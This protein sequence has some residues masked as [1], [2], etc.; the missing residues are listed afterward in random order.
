VDCLFCRIAKGEIEEAFVHE[1][2]DLVAFLD[3]NPI[4]PGHLQIVPRFHYTTFEEMPAEL[5]AASIHL[6][7]R[8]ARAMK[9]L[10]GVARV[11]FADSGGDIAH[12]H[13]HVVP[14][15]ERTDITSLRYIEADNLRFR[16]QPRPPADAL[17]QTVA[18]L[19]AAL[20]D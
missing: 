6:G 8:F 7:Q 11:G 14:M 17:R 2:D 13:A 5:A 10:Y 9:A 20:R 1:D 15:V 16:S 4:R 3:I 19:R 12:A 18:A